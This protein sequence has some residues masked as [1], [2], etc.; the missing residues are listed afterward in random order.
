[1]V[2]DDQLTMVE[3]ARVLLAR[4]PD[5]EL[6]C[7]T[8]SDLAVAVAQRTSP[9]LILQDLVMPG[10]DGIA[11]MRQYAVDPLLADVPVM[12]LSGIEDA[13]EKARA[14]AAGA[15]DYV[16]K[17]PDPVELIARVRAHSSAYRTRVELRRVERTLELAVDQAP[18]GIARTTLEGRWI[19]VND[20]LCEMLGFSRDELLDQ[21][22]LAITHPDNRAPSGTH[23]VT[24]LLTGEVRRTQMEKR[25][26]HR[27]G[28]VVWVR[29]TSS[30]VRDDAG[31][32][33]FLVTQ[34]EDVTAR[35]KAESQ[36][37][38]LFECSRDALVITSPDGT[39]ERV[40]SA[41]TQ[42]LGWS[43]EQTVGQH[44]RSFVHP[45]D[46][47]TLLDDQ[48]ARL[49]VLCRA[50]VNTKD[51]SYRWL[52]WSTARTEDGL[53][54]IAR[55]VTQQVELE[56]L[57]REASLTDELTKLSN[58]R[59]FM[60]LGEQQLANASRHG[61]A[62]LVVFADLDE[63]KRINDEYGHD[64]GDRALIAV[65]DVLRSTFR[66]GDIIARLAGDEFAVLAEGELDSASAVE[67]RL[68]AN[69]E[70]ANAKAGKPY[71]L[72][73]SIG[74]VCS[75]TAEQRSLAELLL[76]ADKLMYESKRRR[77]ESAAAIKA[78][79]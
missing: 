8:R 25:Y 63:M 14:F 61:R 67:A 34:I 43:N 21:G 44:L 29:V 6:T 23:W 32:P 50:R 73:I 33:S 15:V 26:L 78:Q 55:D 45:E 9:T 60:A 28:H 66:R 64:E 42:V 22:W 11:M 20:A 40:N 31:E 70:R 46:V 52:Q 62:L 75:A 53:F 3:W 18:I 57:L 65:A 2:V 36:A 49:T 79:P 69:L 30:L 76:S 19:D 74:V 12:V 41:W 17:F 13:R 54:A 51:G 37:N 1:L 16:V 77:R 27:D 47:A 24:S 4:Q 7:C 59:G 56:Q 39:L 10:R 35:R 58:R 71:A 68:R 38:T 5:L 72:S 48:N